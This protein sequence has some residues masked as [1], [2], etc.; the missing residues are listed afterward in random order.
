MNFEDDTQRIPLATLRRLCWRARLPTVLKILAGA[1]GSFALSFS[2]THALKSHPALSVPKEYPSAA[3][4]V[5]LEVPS[6]VVPA[7]APLVFERVPAAPKK[8]F[9]RKRKEEVDVGF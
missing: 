4:T 6:V 2:V 7:E 9:T 3:P 1:A 5:T 8:S